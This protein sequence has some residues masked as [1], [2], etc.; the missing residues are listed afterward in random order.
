MK[1][2]NRILVAAAM[3]CSAIS[4]NAGPVV[5]GV[6]R[7]ITLADGTQVHA[8]LRGD[9]FGSF[10]Q[11]ADGTCYSLKENTS[12]RYVKADLNKLMLQS[13]ELRRAANV[14][15]AQVRKSP[16]K[17]GKPNGP[18]TGKQKGIIIMVQY[19]DTKFS[20]GYNQKFV[21]GY[22][23]GPMT[24][25][26]TARGFV[27]TVKDYFLAQS[28]GQFELDFDIVGPYTLS[29]EYSYYG[30]DQG[31]TH[32]IHRGAMIL[33]AVKAADA[34]VNYADYD[35]D[36]DGYVDQVYVLFAGHGQADGSDN[37]T[38]WPHE[39]QLSNSELKSSYP[40]QDTDASGNRVVVNT[41]ACGPELLL[42]KRAGIGT[43][44]HEFSHCLGYP[45]MY[46]VQYSGNM[47]MGMWDI[48]DQGSY[49]SD[50]FCP[51]NY[52]AYE[53]WFA[54]WI[55]P[56]VLDKPATVKGVQAQ[57]VNYGQTFVVYNDAN[58]DE[59]YLL[60]N[61]QNN[62]GV[63]DTGLPAS[64][65]MISH[66]DYDE[67]IWSWNYVNTP[68]NYTNLK[69]DHE[70]LTIFCADNDRVN[71]SGYTSPAGDLYPYNGNDELTDTSAPAAVIYNGGKLMGKPI[72]KITQN[73]DGTMDF[74][75]MGGDDN[76]IIAG[77]GDITVNAKQ[78]DKRVFSLDGRYLG[79]DINA[80]G[81]GVFVQ[82]GK[83]IVK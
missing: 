18:I 17:V 29:R 32:D 11:D 23:N 64:G 76:N 5:P 35:W 39:S 78:N 63:W 12:D 71:A 28:N 24:K 51:P 70:R 77:I 49:N 58:K 52:T 14:A 43:L 30:A 73:A 19:K 33:E 42:T 34:D 80:V 69:N 45:D 7:D 79:T 53:K 31:S 75:F 60:E 26:H 3:A 47:G 41:Y 44:C 65:M 81:S 2:L 74:L 68:A 46:D 40:T 66:V 10:W 25:S 82:G 9:E 21:N 13:N 59:Y 72:T 55:E 27:G 15:R 62:I 36:G 38:I 48:M 50:S 61:R 83:K 20:T 37:N 67:K 4:V 22:V 6:W 54:G 16:S 57:D 56:T 1:R 8:Q